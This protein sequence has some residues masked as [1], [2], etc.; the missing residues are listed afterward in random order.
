MRITSRVTCTRKCKGRLTE[1]TTPQEVPAT[2]TLEPL[3]IPPHLRGFCWVTQPI[4][5]MCH[6]LPPDTPSSSSTVKIK[7]RARK[8]LKAT[9]VPAPMAA[10]IS[11]FRTNLGSCLTSKLKTRFWEKASFHLTK[12]I[13]TLWNMR[14]NA[15]MDTRQWA[16]SLRQI[17]LFQIQ[18]WTSTIKI[19]RLSRLTISQTA[20]KI[21]L[22]WKM[23]FRVMQDHTATPLMNS[24]HQ[25]LL[26]TSEATHSWESEETMKA[27]QFCHRK[28]LVRLRR[29]LTRCL[30]LHSWETTST[31][32]LWT[33]VTQII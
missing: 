8:Q 26:P 19:L 1:C 12:L 25:L 21:P 17:H 30:M 18:I 33:G 9:R 4:I 7:V 11:I 10:R 15:K 6:H 16:Q 13:M 28:R 20:R 22:S 31:W 3:L 24:E 27:N 23:T 14:K 2:S 29:S 5:M 32:I